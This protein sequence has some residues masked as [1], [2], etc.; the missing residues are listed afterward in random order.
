MSTIQISIKEVSFINL[1]SY[2]RLS[3][4]NRDLHASYCLFNR[5]TAILDLMNDPDFFACIVYNSYFLPKFSNQDFCSE[6]SR[7]IPSKYKSLHKLEFT[8]W[9]E[10]IE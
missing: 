8:N 3:N 1:S 10:F 2:C 7:A 9:G 6:D 4:R 5:L